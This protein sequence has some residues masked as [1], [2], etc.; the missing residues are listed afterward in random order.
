VFS[1]LLLLDEVP[2]F[3]RDHPILLLFSPVD[4]YLTLLLFPLHTFELVSRLYCLLNYLK[5]LVSFLVQ[6][7]DPVFYDLLLLIDLFFDLL[8]VLSRSHFETGKCA[9]HIADRPEMIFSSARLSSGEAH[10][11]QRSSGCLVRL[12]VD[13]ALSLRLKA[14]GHLVHSSTFL[15]VRLEGQ[16]LRALTLFSCG[17]AQ[18][19]RGNV[20]LSCCIFVSVPSG[21]LG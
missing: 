21:N 15:G 4:S 16:E 19:V 9:A 8:V 17:N 1:D 12:S 18:L 13:D 10:T 11:H 2:S 20:G 5:S 6:A 3:L 7:S 14:L